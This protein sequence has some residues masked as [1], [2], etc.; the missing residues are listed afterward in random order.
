[1]IAADLES[2]S[3]QAQRQVGLSECHVPVLIGYSSGA[4]LVYAALVQSPPGTFAGAQLCPGNG[5][6]YT[7]NPQHELV[8]QPACDSRGL[9]S[10][11]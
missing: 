9:R 4:T 10:R 2:L 3:H 5:L 6:R 7:Q 8:L 11:W 1:M